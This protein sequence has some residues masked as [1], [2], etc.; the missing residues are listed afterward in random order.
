MLDCRRR[1]AAAI[2]QRATAVLLPLPKE[3]FA[4]SFQ[5]LYERCQPF[6]VTDDDYFAGQES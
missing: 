3:V 4:D 6:V 2:Q 1:T 5:Q